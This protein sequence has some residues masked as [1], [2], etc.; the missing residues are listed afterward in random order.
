MQQ[1][2]LD[3]R[4]V[5]PALVGCVLFIVWVAGSA[6]AQGA[7]LWLDPSSLDLAP[8]DVKTVDVRVKNVTGLAGAE[9][10]L[11]YDPAL[12]EVVDADA[13][14][15]GVQIAHGDFLSPDF[16]VQNSADGTAGTVDYAI[17][18]MSLDNAVSGDGVLARITFRGLSKGKTTIAVQSVLLADKDGKP[19]E[20]ETDSSQ[21]VVGGSGFSIVWV[22]I[23]LAGIVVLI[24]AAMI[25]RNVAL[26][27]QQKGGSV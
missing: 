16:V 17:A 5:A 24:G 27:R 4:R 6:S 3:V 13:E 9:V 15:D 26:S 19:I 18:C 21:A 11:T 20:V 7:Q 1:L 8:G 23:A 10:H 25:L 22:L 14:V 2:S 12:L